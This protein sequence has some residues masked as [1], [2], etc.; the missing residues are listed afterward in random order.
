MVRAYKHKSHGPLSCPS[1]PY[2]NDNTTYE[3][4]DASLHV[5]DALSP[6]PSARIPNELIMF[7]NIIRPLAVALGAALA[8]PVLASPLSRRD[9]IAPKITS[10]NAQSIWPVGSTQTVTWYEPILTSYTPANCGA[11][12]W[13]DMTCHLH[14]SLFVCRDTSNFPP[15]SQ[16]TNILGQVILGFQANDSLNL[17]FGRWPI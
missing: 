11:C 16:I 4:V 2:I 3:L 10:P 14:A 7:S 9:V 17:D 13:V 8:L 6:F 5:H 1:R 12:C 15:V